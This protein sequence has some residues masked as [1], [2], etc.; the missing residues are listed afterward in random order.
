M[1][2]IFLLQKCHS[3]K[4]SVCNEDTLTRN[5]ILRKLKQRLK[6]IYEFS[7]VNP[8]FV[9]TNI[10]KS[11]KTNLSYIEPPKIIVKKHF[12]VSFKLFK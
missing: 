12:F 6:F 1:D 10:R 2:G 4:D 5:T 7:K 9:N 8:T 11:D 3:R